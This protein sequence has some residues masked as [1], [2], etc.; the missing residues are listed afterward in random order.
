MNG[1]R[2]FALATAAVGLSGV[3]QEPHSALASPAH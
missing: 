3:R 2:A 1:L